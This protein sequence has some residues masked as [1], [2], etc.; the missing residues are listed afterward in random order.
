MESRHYVIIFQMAVLSGRD[1]ADITKQ[2][3]RNHEETFLW[4][5]IIKTTIYKACVL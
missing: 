3:D 5:L 4:Y 1:I 2:W